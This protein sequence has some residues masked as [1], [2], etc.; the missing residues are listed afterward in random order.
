MNNSSMKPT[1]LFVDDEER[2]VNLL[3]MVFRSDYEVLTACSGQQA[4]DLLDRHRVAV[5]VSDQRMPGMLGVQLLSE[6]R[7]RSPATMRILLTGYSDLAAI[8]GS[9][10]EGEVF[11]FVNK[12]W[13]HDEIKAIVREAADASLATG[14]SLMQPGPAMAAPH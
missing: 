4:L 6:A 9:V 11:R 14:T 3:R 5:L 8:V 2:I 13:N 12:P 7:K 1:V 10:N